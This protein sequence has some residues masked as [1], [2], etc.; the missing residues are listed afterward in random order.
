MGADGGPGL[1]QM[2]DSGSKTMAQDENSRV[3]WGMPGEAV[4]LEATDYVLPLNKIAQ[5][6]Q[7]L[8]SEAK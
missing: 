3:V 1:K 7:L 2:H 5:K 4:K 8:I 6:I